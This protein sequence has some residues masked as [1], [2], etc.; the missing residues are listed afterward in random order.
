M[1]KIKKLSKNAIF[2]LLKR[3]LKQS[4]S[5]YSN[6]CVSCIV[7]TKYNNKYNYYYGNNIENISYGLTICAERVGLFNYLTN[8]KDNECILNLYILASN[9]KDFIDYIYPCGACLGVMNEF[10]KEK[11]H[12][13]CFSIVGKW[14]RFIMNDL[15]PFGFAI[16]KEENKNVR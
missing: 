10:L 2:F 9:N 11:N 5:P 16:R 8:K 1:T 3:Q 7:E 15:L 12:I 4:Y 6:F 13:Y 14:R